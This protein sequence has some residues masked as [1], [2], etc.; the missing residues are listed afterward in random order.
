MER[1]DYGEKSPRELS[2]YFMMFAVGFLVGIVVAALMEPETLAD[3]GIMSKN[4]LLRLKYMEVD[5]NG[6]F[7]YCIRK[8]GF[9][10]ALLLV[11]ACSN[12]AYLMASGYCVWQGISAGVLVSAFAMQFGVGG[13]IFYLALHFPHGIFYII[14]VILY[15][16]WMDGVQKWLRMSKTEKKNMFFVKIIQLFVILTMLL[17]GILLES[18]VNPIIFHKIVKFF[19]G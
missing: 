5:G 1:R 6:L 10:A 8:R 11:F 17:L 15:F 2:F 7:F 16:F 19:V 3:T 14:T 4:W 13:P 12:L 9:T 18:Y